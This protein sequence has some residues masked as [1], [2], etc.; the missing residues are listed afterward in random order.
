[1]NSSI[2]IN[3]DF[4]SSGN[5]INEDNKNKIAAIVFF[6]FNTPK[7]YFS[8]SSQRHKVKKEV[9]TRKALKG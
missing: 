8:Q 9:K 2:K 1:V 7:K 4:F 6:I 3:G 5:N